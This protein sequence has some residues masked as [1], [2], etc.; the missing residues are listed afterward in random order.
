M[1]RPGLSRLKLAAAD[2]EDLQI[3]SARLQDAVVKLKNFIWLPKKRRFAAVV[4][5]LAWEDGGKTRVRSGLHFDGVLKVQSSKVKLGAGEAVVSVLAVGFTPNKS[6]EG[7]GEDPGGVIEIV[8]AGG[9]ALRLTVECIDAELADMS[10]PWAA[11]GTP[12]HEAADGP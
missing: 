5:R 9:G 2:P 8:L 7:G 12:D 3:L 4:N 11:R 10:G 6:E 1:S